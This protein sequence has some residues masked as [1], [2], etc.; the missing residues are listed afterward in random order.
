MPWP[1]STS[2]TT[3]TPRTSAPGCAAIKPPRSPHR[4]G[5]VRYHEMVSPRQGIAWMR[6][7]PTAADCIAAAIL[8]AVAISGIWAGNIAKYRDP[9]LWAVL[10][11]IAAAG[12][13]GWRR[14][15][16]DLVLVSSVPAA[17]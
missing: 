14:R 1:S 5:L 15:R 10:L 2:C 17:V 16:P 12:P 13:L 9:D 4:R 7:H 6:S 8:L 3:P 11:T